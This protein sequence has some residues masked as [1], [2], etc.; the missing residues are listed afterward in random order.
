MAL[1]ERLLWA[2]AVAVIAWLICIFFGGFLATV[3]QPQMA[4]VGQ[5]L[6]KFATVVAV[7]AFIIA[8][9]GGAPAGIASL[10]KRG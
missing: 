1:V 3:N 4:Y 9:V 7:V 5:F 6:E 2:L 10:F 8:F